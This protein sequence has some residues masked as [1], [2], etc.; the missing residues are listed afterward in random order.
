[1]W[2][3]FGE[4]LKTEQMFLVSSYSLL[5]HILKQWRSPQLITITSNEYLVPMHPLSSRTFWLPAILTLVGCGLL[6]GWELGLFENWIWTPLRP[7][8]STAESALTGIIALLLSADVGL[9]VWRTRHGTCPAGTKR[10]AG[11][12]GILGIVTLL[13]PVCIAL[14][15]SIASV[16]IAMAVLSS[17]VPLLRAIAVV[18]LLTA[19][20]M[21]WPRNARRKRQ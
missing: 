14:P 18:L 2:E 21:L 20:W 15:V 7:E 10:A 16:G 8:R 1:M 4:G 11:I 17:F 6:F 5:V 13:C 12:A 3:R 9:I 19:G